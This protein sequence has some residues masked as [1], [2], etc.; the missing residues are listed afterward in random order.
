M[1][2]GYADDDMLGVSNVPPGLIGTSRTLIHGCE[3][4]AG[5]NG[6]VRR[7]GGRGGGTKRSDEI[8]ERKEG[9]GGGRHP[10][11][12]KNEVSGTGQE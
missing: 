12:C 3:R 1:S 9:G 7:G 8:D 11:T 6:S 10:I 5:M 2:D 4:Q